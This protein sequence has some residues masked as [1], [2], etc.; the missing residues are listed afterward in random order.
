MDREE[1]LVLNQ[2]LLAEPSSRTNPAEDPQSKSLP[3][4]VWVETK[5][6]WRVVGPA[7]IA[8]VAGY[9]MT[10]ITQAFAGHLGDNELAAISIVNNVI[11]GFSFGLLVLFSNT[12]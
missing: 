9:S 7:I 4:R 3:S 5:K 2:S 6:L 1:E 12:W 8:R 11:L 10:V